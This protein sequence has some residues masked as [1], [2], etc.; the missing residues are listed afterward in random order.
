MGIMNKRNAFLGWAVWNLGK[1]VAKRKARNAV[2]GAGG[3]GGGKAKSAGAV[4][5][6]LAAAAG[7]FWF[8]HRRGSGDEGGP[9]S[10][11]F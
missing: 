4:V 9:G 7:A 3:G 5:A 11:D 8:W 10:N 1:R 6:V 2:P